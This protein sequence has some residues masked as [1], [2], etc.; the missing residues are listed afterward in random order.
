MKPST[1]A[2]SQYLASTE[3]L[4]ARIAI[5]DYS[6]N[7]QSWW[8]WLAERFRPTGDVLEVGAGT[9]KLWQHIDHSQA[10]L[11]LV[12]FSPAMCESL[13]GLQ[14]QDATIVRSDAAKLP[15]AD[16]SFDFLVANHMLYH[17]D[18]PD[19]VLKEFAR[20]LRRGGKLFVTLN[21]RQHMAEVAAVST[22]VGGRRML[23]ETAPMVADNAAEYLSKEFAYV[24]PEAFPGDLEV[25]TS[26]PVLAYI[27]S[28]NGDITAAQ[29]VEARK[30]ID[31]QITS[32]GSFQSQKKVYLFTA[33]RP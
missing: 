19:A 18:D 25:P 15:F 31:D 33:I 1:L 10:K 16:S 21:G 27:E 32:K 26:E 8:G 24:E 4:T 23:L 9:G 28:L 6:T 12:D 30:M 17:V 3:K 5:Y 11:T 14:L 29:K 22:A 13:R 20:V 7:P 2:E